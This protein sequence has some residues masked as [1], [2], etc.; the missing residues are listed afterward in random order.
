MTLKSRTAVVTGS[1]SGIGLAYARALAKAGANVMI[2]GFGPPDG[3]EKE[4]SAI[5]AEFGVRC[6]Y[7]GADMTKPEDICGMIAQ[8]AAAFGA[9]RSWSRQEPAPPPRFQQ[10]RRNPKRAG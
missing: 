7:S 8:A 5:E 9:R 3:I 10:N 1:T 2:N 6:L 4:R